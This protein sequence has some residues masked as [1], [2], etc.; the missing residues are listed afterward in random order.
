MSKFIADK[1]FFELFP[2]AKLGVV[3][4]KGME[5]SD[6]S[7]IEV[8]KMLLDANDEAEKYL[9]AGQLSENKEV[10]VW[11]EAYKKFK[12]KKGARCSIEALLK[13]L[14]KGNIVGSI[15]TLVDI[16]NAASLKYA[17]PCGAEDSDKFVGDLRLTITEG[18]DPFQAIGEDASETYPGE[19]CYKDDAGAIC[20]C[21]NWRDGIR[22][23]IT[24]DTKNAFMIMELVDPDRYDALEGAM[25]F[26]KENLEKYLNADVEVHILDKDNPEVNIN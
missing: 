24:E 6:E 15:N 1:S 9:V 17:L 12:T 11:R 22:T 7:P 10:A 4:V 16:Y 3:L 8:K 18:G 26:L 23:M 25:G 2:D 19:L 13:R 14:S 5:N 20:R 21:F